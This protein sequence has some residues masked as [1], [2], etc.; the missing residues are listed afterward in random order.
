MAESEWNSLGQAVSGPKAGSQLD[1]VVS[2]NHFGFSWAAFRPETR[3]Y[4]TD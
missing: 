3:V 2:T 1:P 4:G